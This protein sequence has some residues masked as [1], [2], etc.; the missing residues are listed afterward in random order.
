MC[1]YDGIIMIDNTFII[2]SF[3]FIAIFLL[4]F[5][6]FIVRNLMCPGVVCTKTMGTIIQLNCSWKVNAEGWHVRSFVFCFHFF[7]GVR[8]MGQQSSWDNGPIDE[9]DDWQIS[10][11]CLCVCVC[12]VG[13]CLTS[14]PWP[15]PSPPRQSSPTEK[16]QYGKDKKPNT[17][18]HSS[19]V[20]DRKKNI[21]DWH[22]SV[23]SQAVQLS[24][25][26]RKVS[27]PRVAL[28]I[29]DFDYKST[30]TTTPPLTK[31]EHY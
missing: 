13:M 27:L 1:C 17:F 21:I 30:I 15:Q 22:I 12:Y 11:T 23:G 2:L 10:M 9:Q 28:I 24:F 26:R 25:I 16:W 20:L 29:F 3:K 5:N 31:R 7:F 4:L 8:Q 19:I 18:D 6:R 14:S